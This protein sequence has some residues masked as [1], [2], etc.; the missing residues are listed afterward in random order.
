MRE[1]GRSAAEIGDL[2]RARMFFAEAWESAHI[3]GDH[4]KP[5]TAGLSADCAILDFDLGNK[6]SALDLMRRALLE[7][8]DLDPRA[9]L[10]HAFVKRVHIAAI[11]YMRGAA[12]DF[13]AARQV[14]VYGMCS[15]PEPQSWFQDQPQPQPAF[16]WYLLAELES[17]ISADQ[18]ILTELRKRTAANSLI[19]METTLASRI[20]EVAVRDLHVDRFLSAI[21]TYPRAVIEGIRAMKNGGGDPFNMPTGSLPPITE[22]EWENNGIAETSKNVVLCFML[23]CSAVGRADI[24]ADFRQKIMAVPGLAQIVEDLFRVMDKPSDNRGDVYLIIPS[25]VGR[26]LKGEILNTDDVFL[27]A[28]FAVQFLEG[29]VLA[30]PAASALMSFYERLWRE[31]LEKRK[32]SMRGP[33]TNGPIIL[34]AMQKGE[35][36]L[37]RM[38]NMVLA[39]EA[40][41]KHSLSNDLRQRLSKVATK[42]LKPDFTQDG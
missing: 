35:T 23:V 31:I 32:F 21:T 29:G 4:M 26:L 10:R 11:L 15:E 41:S 13:P 3:C 18:A 37:Q 22:G 42:R 36:A 12:A 17:E 16:V 8:D 25:I 28:M 40:A 34:E 6:Q 30:P 33:A 38:A 14:M 19:P 1:A 24:M 5:M 20:I 2:E 7:A 9:G 39:T 27:S